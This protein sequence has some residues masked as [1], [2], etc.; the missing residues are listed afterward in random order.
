MGDVTNEAAERRDR[1]VRRAV[2]RPDRRDRARP[3]RASSR[4]GR[5]RS[6]S[7]LPDDLEPRDHRADPAARR[8]RTWPSASGAGRV[9]LGRPRRAR[10]R[11]PARLADDQRQDA[12]A[13][14]RPARVRRRRS[15]ADGLD[16]AVLLGMGGSSLGP[17]V[18]R[19]SYGDVPDGLRLH[20]LDSTDPGAVLARRARGGPRQDAVHRLLEVRR[21]DRDAVAHALLLRAHRSATAARFVRGHRPGQP[22]DRRWPASA[23]SGA[24]SR[25][26][27]T[28]AAATRCCRT[29][30]SCR[31]R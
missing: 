31:P 5:R 24:C 8:P 3:A 6:Q 21:D 23:A 22:A 9:A 12:R 2:R 27:R 4:A 18:I 25:T 13:R 28:S 1:Q 29:S 19:R 15:K 20:V 30:G 26:T 16:H 7:S 11:Q 17:E 10:D 14:G